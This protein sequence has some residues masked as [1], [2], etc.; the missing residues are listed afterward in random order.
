MYYFPDLRYSKRPARLREYPAHRYEEAA[1]I[2]RQATQAQSLQNQREDTRAITNYL[3]GVAVLVVIVSHYAL[4]YQTEFYQRY[5]PEYAGMALAI[6]FILS[7]Y[8]VY[9]SLERRYKSAAPGQRVMAGFLFD[10]AF[11]IY[12][13]YWLAVLAIALFPMSF[14]LHR[15]NLVLLGIILGS[16]RIFWFVTA[17]IQCYLVAPILFF[18]YKKA[19]LK[20]FMA[21]NGLFF[22][23]SLAMSYLLANSL[24]WTENGY[25]AVLMYRQ[26]FLGN[27]VMFSFGMM[28][29]GIIGRYGER[30]RR[31]WFLLALSLAAFLLALHFNRFGVRIYPAFVFGL[32]AFCT[33]MIVVRP[34]L[35]LGRVIVALGICSYELYLFHRVYFMLLDEAGI[36]AQGSL[37]SILYTLLMAPILVATCIV[38]EKGFRRA[39]ARVRGSVG[40]LFKEVELPAPP[41]P[42]VSG[43]TF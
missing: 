40:P 19:G 14:L 30:F 36:T 27:I 38:L 4:S 20:R 28:M 11:C 35:P 32:F 33:L 24:D 31:A 10:R 34:R 18:A 6:F 22:A 41:L 26:F 8:G 3:K 21:F 29:P 2:K 43:E 37:A 16:P 1:I 9:L 5:M 7:G 39:H 23:F 25:F 42:S 17:I 15:F 12:A 13:P